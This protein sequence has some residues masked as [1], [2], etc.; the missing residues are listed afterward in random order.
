MLIIVIVISLVF[1][2]IDSIGNRGMVVKGTDC[3]SLMGL[4]QG[5]SDRGK[6]G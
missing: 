4:V 3:G 6:V 1:M 5:G 2:A